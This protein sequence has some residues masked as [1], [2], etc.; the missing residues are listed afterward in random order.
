MPYKDRTTGSKLYSYYGTDCFST[1]ANRK[2]EIHWNDQTNFSAYLKNQH[3]RSI[4]LIFLIIV[5]LSIT[6]SSFA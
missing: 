4:S 5:K 1:R 6:Y 3:Y 2:R